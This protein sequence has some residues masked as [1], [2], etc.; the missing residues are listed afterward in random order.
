MSQKTARLGDVVSLVQTGPFGSQLHCS[1]YT[2]LGTPVIMP[3]NLVRRSISSENIARVE[4][5]HVQRLSRHKVRKGDILYSRRGDV[6]RSAYVTQ[7]EEGWLCGTGCLLVRPDPNII[8]PLYLSY[9]LNEA[10]T[11]EWVKNH[12]IGSTMPNLNT[13][14][15]ENIPVHFPDIDQQEKVERIVSAYDTLIENNQKQIKLLEEAARRLYKEWFVDLRFPGHEHTPI[16]NGIPEGWTM[17][18]T[19]DVITFDPSV[20]LEK[21]QTRENVP[22]TALSTSGCT[23][24][25]SLITRTTSCSGSRFLNGDTL[26]ARIS[27]SLENGK[28]AYVQGLEGPAVGSTEY[29][30]MRG[31]SI[32]SIMVY[33]YARTEHFRKVAIGS[34]KGSDGRQRAQKDMLTSLPYVKA[35]DTL[36][37]DFEGIAQ[38]MFTLIEQLCTYNQHLTEARDRLLPKLMSGEIAIK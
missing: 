31:K 23:L 28:T 9:M 7:N 35:P 3:V 37:K 10:E 22:M 13:S 36:L 33:L 6:G 18:Q 2:E 30:V 4:D 26:L 21:G 16:V 27:P 20:K 15:L 12:A 5:I 11:V 8:R 14:I 29:I 24:D 38:P 32:P 25:K 34:M 17:L 19:A 1:D